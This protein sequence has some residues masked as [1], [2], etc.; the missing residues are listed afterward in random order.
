MLEVLN[1]IG[2]KCFWFI[3]QGET[4]LSECYMCTS[5]QFLLHFISGP[6]CL[7]TKMSELRLYCDLLVQQVQTIK[8]QHSDDPETPPTSEVCTYFFI[9]EWGGLMTFWHQF[10]G[11]T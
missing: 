11:L 5:A 7:K 9:I 4:S 8:S 6:D 2:N 3:V 1:R 10:E